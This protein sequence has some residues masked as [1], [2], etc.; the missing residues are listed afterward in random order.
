MSYSRRAFSFRKTILVLSTYCE[1]HFNVIIVSIYGYQD[2]SNDT[3][4]VLDLYCPLCWSPTVFAENIKIYI[5]AIYSCRILSSW[6]TS[7]SLNINPKRSYAVQTVIL[8]TLVSF[9]NLTC[10]YYLLKPQQVFLWVLC[11]I[12]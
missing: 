4:V 8:I 10:L 11:K 1:A 12:A 5:K 3:N 6:V 2:H 7:G 9:N